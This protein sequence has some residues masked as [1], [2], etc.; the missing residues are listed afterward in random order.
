M[1]SVLIAKHFKGQPFAFATKA[2]LVGHTEQ[3]TPAHPAKPWISV[4][5][6]NIN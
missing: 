3:M 2:L 5:I 6:L 4:Q 1:E